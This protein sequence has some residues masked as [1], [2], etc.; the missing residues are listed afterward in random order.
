[1]KEKNPVSLERTNMKRA[2]LFVRLVSLACLVAVAASASSSLS[3]GQDKFKVKEVAAFS[4][5][6]LPC[7]GPYTDMQTKFGQLV[8]FM[9]AQN[10]V[11]MGPLMGVYYNDPSV[12]KPENLHWEIGFPAM[13]SNV[14]DPLRFKQWTF[15]TVVEAMHTGPYEELGSIY[16]EIMDWMDANGY[17]PAG[18]FLEQY[19]S[20]PNSTRQE[21][22]KTQIWV[23]CRKK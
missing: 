9:Q 5:C 7:Q 1:M 17:A 11:P 12:T 19:L 22:I 6:C 21:D 4:Y 13:A 20:D 3:P 10:L 16:S 14:Q 15:T 8:Q 23:P 18:P 2:I